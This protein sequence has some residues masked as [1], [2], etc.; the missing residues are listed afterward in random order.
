MRSVRTLS[1][2]AL[3]AALAALG[4]CGNLVSLGGGEPVD[5]RENIH[6][7]G[8]SGSTGS[9]G[10]TGGEGTTTATTSSSSGQQAC[11]PGQDEDFDADGFSIA[12]GDCN[13]CDPL[14]NPGAMELSTTPGQT[15]KDDNCNGVVDEPSSLCDTGLS[16]D[17]NDP[18]H[19]ANAADICKIASGPSDWGLLSAFWLLPDGAQ[20][21]Q[22]A[23]PNYALGHGIM[24]SF[25]PN[26]T[27]H[28]GDNMLVLSSG[29]ARTPADPG[30]AMNFAKGYTSNPPDGFPKPSPSCIDA[31]GQNPNDGASL[32]LTLRAP[33]NVAGLGFDFSFYTSEW[34]N[35]VC[36]AFNDVFTATLLPKPG[37]L[38]D[39]NITFDQLNNPI[40]VNNAFLDVCGCVGGPPCFAG[41]K[42]YACAQGTGPLLGTG[43]D[44]GGL[45]GMDNASTG[46]LTTL[47]PVEPGGIVQ[48]RW[49][50]YDASDGVLDST[51]VIDN[52]RWITAPVPVVVTYRPQP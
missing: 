29:T 48:L 28:A 41:G 18:V 35:F 27:P 15:P 42:T 12:Q 32:D 25:G 40:T 36:S 38:P 51:V 43:F 19:A 33:T 47:A 46:W 39:G 4:A 14:V 5:P 7:V 1:L 31:T 16:L 24:G 49:S 50:V 17:D 30:Y 34:P 23:G 21:P 37:N 26:V 11:D 6:S 20:I 3:P 8:G 45:G 10:G 13:D 52:F 9:S 44:A 22:G 2:L